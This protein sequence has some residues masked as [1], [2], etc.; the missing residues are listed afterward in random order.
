MALPT[1]SSD[2]TCPPPAAAAPTPPL[3]N[4]YNLNKVMDDISRADNLGK[5]LA[6]ILLQRGDEQGNEPLLSTASYNKAV[7]LLFRVGVQVHTTCL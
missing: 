6:R 1:S 5:V 7:A 2:L 4:D 3:L